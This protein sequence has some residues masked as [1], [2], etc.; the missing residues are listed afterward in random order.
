[1]FQSYELVIFIPMYHFK[2]QQINETSVDRGLKFK[3]MVTYMY[4]N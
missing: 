1:M 3:N 2:V 4:I